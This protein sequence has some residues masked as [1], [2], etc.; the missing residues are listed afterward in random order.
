MEGDVSSVQEAIS[1]ADGKKAVAYIHRV[2]PKTEVMKSS[3]HN[4]TQPS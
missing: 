2:S 3:V 4:I 1:A